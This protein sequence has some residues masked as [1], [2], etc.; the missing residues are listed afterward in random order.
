MYFVLCARIEGRAPVTSLFQEST[1]D[2]SEDLQQVNTLVLGVGNSLCGDD[3]AGPRIIEI[4]TE[5]GVPPGTQA[6]DAGLPGWGLPIWLE[7]WSSVLL[8]DAVDM[9][10]EAGCWQRFQTE[11]VKLWLQAETLSL[12]QPDLACGL[13]LARALDIMPEHLYIYGVQPAHTTPGA[14]LSPQVNACLPG[15]ADQI[16]LDIRKIKHDTKANP[17]S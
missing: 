3:G 11:D 4:L 13:A 17:H 5:R 10:L 2:F 1:E 16:I 12:H 7:G 8:V 14:P 9:N 15:L 6:R